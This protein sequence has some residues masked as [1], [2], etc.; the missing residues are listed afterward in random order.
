MRA[1][2]RIAAFFAALIFISPAQAQ[3][4]NGKATTAAPSYNTGFPYPLSLDL[5]GNLRVIC[6]SGCSS[7]G[8]QNVNLTQILG[9]APSLTNPLWITPA[10]GASFPVTGTFF[11]TTQPVSAASWPLPTNAAQETGGNL[12]AVAT[13]T[14]TTATNTGTIA[15]AVSSARV[16]TNVA[17]INGVTPLMGNGAT[18]TGSPRV[19]IASD[20]SAV[21][22]AGQGATASAVPAGATLAGAR[23]G[24]NLVPLI[25]ADASAGFGISTATT[26]QIVA[27]SGST[28]IYVTSFDV[29]A[30]GTGNVSFVYGTGSNCGTGTT[31]LTGVYP[32]TAQAGIAK[33]SGLG[34]VLVVPAGNALCVTTSAAVQMSGSV[35]YTQF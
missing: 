8:T 14:G 29:I 24:A 4:A 26:T 7:G 34:P 17:Q 23:S 31:A 9:A 12:A 25:Q 19:T 10:T 13:N 16:Q 20:N 6:V 32:L 33:G 28:K 3:Y 22:A 18:G 30:G 11:Q 2:F 35:S 27:L 21:P 1:F 15:G 5:A